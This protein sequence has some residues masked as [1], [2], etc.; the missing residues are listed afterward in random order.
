MIVSY[1]ETLRASARNA[2]ARNDCKTIS[3]FSHKDSDSDKCEH[4]VRDERATVN[5][6]RPSPSVVRGSK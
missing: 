5:I 2:F 4:T 3:K 6:S 1:V